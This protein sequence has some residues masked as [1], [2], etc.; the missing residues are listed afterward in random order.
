MNLY[1]D[2]HIPLTLASILATHGVDCLTT[3]ADEK[4][5][6]CP[7][8]TSIANPTMIQYDDSYRGSC[9]KA[10]P[11]KDQLRLVDQ[12]SKGVKS[13]LSRPIN[14][15]P[16][17]RLGRQPVICGVPNGSPHHDTYLYEIPVKSE[18]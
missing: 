2:E 9:V 15:N 10:P 11:Q 6:V 16:I 5:S 7:L 8:G 3:Q 13:I 12:R 17:R 18:P 1:F 4:G 14:V